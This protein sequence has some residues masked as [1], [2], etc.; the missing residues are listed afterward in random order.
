MNALSLNYLHQLKV[1][2]TQHKVSKGILQFFTG[3]INHYKQP[4]VGEIRKGVVY[5]VGAGPGDAEL[6]TIKAYRLLQQVDVVMYDWLVDPQI[7]AMIPEHVEKVFVGKRCGKH[8]MVQSDICQLLVDTALSGKNI[9]RL[10]GGDPAV[11]ARLAEE[12][13]ILTQHAIQYAVVPG[14][15]SASGASAYTGISLTHRQCAQSVRFITAHLKSKTEQP[16]WSQMVTSQRG[17]NG[18]TLVFYMGLK[19]I[20]M[21][22][23]NL[24]AHGMEPDTPA[25][26][27]DKACTGEQQ[28]CIADIMHISA[29]AEQCAFGGPAIIIVGQAVTKRSDV[30]LALLAPQYLASTQD[31]TND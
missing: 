15:T 4:R 9:V 1:Q 6:L 16:N 30:N 29:K 11:F 10:K 27:I 21:I 26:V 24:M 22:M 5:L 14:V 25:A 20:S 28:I 31:A 8:S 12:C 13:E 17:P 2:L 7:L 3:K 19:R 18:E 23:N